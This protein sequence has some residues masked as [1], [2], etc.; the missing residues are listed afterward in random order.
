M[1]AAAIGSAGSTV[2]RRRTL[3]FVLSILLHGLVLGWFA[4]RQDRTPEDAAAPAVVVQLLDIA[5]LPRPPS[6]ADEENASEAPVIRPVFP[7][8]P[9]YVGPPA[10]EGG[11]KER[12]IDL[13]GPVFADGEWPRP[14][15]RSDCDPVTDPEMTGPACQREGAIARG[16]NRAFDP[17]EGTDEF[18]REARRN[19]A[20]K[21]YRDAPG[22]SGYPGIRCHVLHNC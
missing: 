2:R 9:R 20:V 12:G 21:R 3:V 8:A 14:W 1:T 10:G 4:F 15:T 5:K 6:R 22:M 18:A 19:E 7:V 13:F 17:N 16:V 11:A